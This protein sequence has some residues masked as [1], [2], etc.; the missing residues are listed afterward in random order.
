MCAQK[1]AET[2]DAQTQDVLDYLNAEN[3]YLEEVMKPQEALKESLYNEIVGRIKK[4]DQSV[5]IK[6]NGYSYYSRYEEGMDYPL[7]CRKK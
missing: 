1:N 4:D 2:P 5:P 3:K 6:D 7:Y